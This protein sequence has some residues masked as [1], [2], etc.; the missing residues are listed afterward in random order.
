MLITGISGFVGR[1]LAARFLEQ[2]YEV[3]GSVQLLTKIGCDGI[4]SEVRLNQ[5][6]V[7]LIKEAVA[8]RDVAARI[9]LFGSRANPASRG[10]DIDILVLSDRIGFRDELRIRREILDAIGWQKLDLLVEKKDR[11][12]RPIAQIAQS[13]GVEL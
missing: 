13:T 1:Q 8:K 12:L 6:Q 11:P 5:E 3:L 2:G 10:G 7:S 4:L 9:Y